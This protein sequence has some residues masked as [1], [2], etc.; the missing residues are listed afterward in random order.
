MTDER[1]PAA[2]AAVR[3]VVVLGSNAD[4][5]RRLQQARSE[6]ERAAPVLAASDEVGAPSYL[7][8]DA[9]IYRN[10]ALM[11]E[12]AGAPDGFRA[13]ARDI[14]R[15]LGRRREATDAASGEVEIDIDLVAGF[16]GD[17]ALLHLAPEKLEPELLRA[18]VRQVVSGRG[19][20]E[21]DAALG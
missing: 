5:R 18:L 3:L 9:S 13:L 11:L 16:G 19:R 2:G 7:P 17:G 20:V 14:E 4:A 6:L 10:Q 1:V 15:R 8:G 12:W 21:L